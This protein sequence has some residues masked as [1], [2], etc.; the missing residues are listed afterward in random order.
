[1][2]SEYNLFETWFLFKSN[3]PKKDVLLL[4]PAYLLNIQASLES[5]PL[6]LEFPENDNDFMSKPT[7]SASRIIG[8]ALIL[9]SEI[10]PNEIFSKNNLSIS[11]ISSYEHKCRW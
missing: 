2:I 5:I 8:S 9:F 6:G 1:M 4:W 11:S 3:N 7:I 10:S